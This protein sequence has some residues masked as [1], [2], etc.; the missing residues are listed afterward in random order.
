MTRKPFVL[1]FL[2]SAVALLQLLAM[3]PAKPKNDPA[4]VYLVHA[5][6]LRYDRWKN[7]DAQVLTGNVQFEHAGARLFCDS[8]NFFEASN[9]FEAFGHVKMLQGDTLSLVSDYGYYDGNDQLMQALHH[10]V[11]KNRTTTLYTDSLYYDRLWNLG[12]F[13]EGG[14]LVDNGT[15]LTSDWGEYH[16][17]TKLAIFYYD[18][19]MTDKQ[20][21]L[22]TDSLYYDTRQK[23]A[24]IIGPSD[25]I[26]G[27]SHIYS[28]LGYYDT[29]TEQAEL[30]NRSRLDNQGRMLVGDSLWHDGKRGVS[31]AF[32]NVEFKDSVNKNILLCNYGYYEDS[33][34]YALCTDSAVVIDYSQ[35]DSLFMHADTFKV[36]SYNLNTDSVYRVIHGYNKVRAYRIDIQAVCDSLV[37]SS[38]DS[39]MTLYKDPIVWNVNQQLFGEVIKVFM[40]DSV[41]DHAHVIDQAF[42]IE[43]LPQKD[44]YNQV[45][46]KEMFAFF[47]NGEIHEAQAKDNVLVAYYPEDQADS[48]YVG[49]VSMQTSELRMFMEQRKL[50]R[51]WAPKSEGVMYPLSQIPP[52]K[53][54]LEGFTW[55]DYVRPLSKDDIFNW[56]P[57][58][59][60]TELKPQKRREPPRSASSP[61]PTSS[62]SPTSPTSPTS[63][64]SQTSPS[65]L[66][67]SSIAA[68]AD[69]IP[70]ELSSPNS[71]Q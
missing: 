15:T 35:R 52:E 63:L 36:F 1:L 44:L 12:Y 22:A 70:S 51:I 40:K 21:N 18:V 38:L 48:S 29:R 32:R 8:A 69:S 39:C 43:Q 59:K 28:E 24:H 13:E 61:S 10:V 68:P 30:L 7:N 26:S 11:L 17:D 64:S 20:F 56:R 46:S 9:S 33:I 25:I 54:Y 45:S 53:R 19:K 60:G 37:Y 58:N 3:P 42:S 31:E 34:G 16:T 50:S 57:K 67:S 27:R 71:P 41:I 55:F 62:T 66:S 14:K 5:D 6:E 65:S 2:L 4:R 23:K 49:L 47:I